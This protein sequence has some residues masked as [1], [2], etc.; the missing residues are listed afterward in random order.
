[1]PARILKPEQAAEAAHI[2]RAGGLVGFPT[3]TIYG[4]AGLADNSFNNAKLRALKGGRPEPFSLHAGDVE[5][6]LHFA[7]GLGPMECR[8]ARALTPHGATL[9]VAAASRPHGLGLRVVRHGLGSRLLLAV[10]AP[11]VATSANLHGQPV[12]NDAAAIAALPGVD[13][14]LDAGPLPPR[15][16]S[17]VARMLPAGLQVLREGALPAP[18]LARRCLT[19]VLFVCLGNLNRS[20]FAHG[21]VHT[22]QERLAALPR[23]V[24]LFAPRSRGTIAHPAM[25]V[26]EPMLEAA[27]ARGVDLSRHTPKPLQPRDPADADLVVAMGDEVAGDVPPGALNLRV[28]DPMGGEAAE[29]A[30]CARTIACRLRERLLPGWAVGDA[31]DAAFKA[32]LDELFFRDCNGSR[33]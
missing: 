5:S 32:E 12:L 19:R 30:A 21:L 11:V 10:G 14:V 22:L 9:V 17:T 20:A 27:L 2:L 24:P 31:V 29:F 18:E 15:P 6:A 1:M 25:T 16:A 28:P 33:T 3:D 7:G 26:P 13:A 4:V 23:F 8:L